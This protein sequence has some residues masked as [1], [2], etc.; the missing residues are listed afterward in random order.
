MQM[1]EKVKK[2]KWSLFLLLLIFV[3]TGTIFALGKAKYSIANRTLEGKYNRKFDVLRVYSKAPG[4]VWVACRMVDI[5]DHVIEI[6]M[7]DNCRGIIREYEDDVYAVIVSQEVEELLEEDLKQFFAKCWVWVD[8]SDLRISDE[9]FDPNTASVEDIIKKAEIGATVG[10]CYVD[11][12]IDR[13]EGTG[14][15]YEKE[16]LYF[17]QGIENYIEENKIFQICLRL[18]WV[19]EEES[20]RVKECLMSMKTKGDYYDM[21]EPLSKESIN[22]IKKAPAYV[23]SK[24]EYIL[25]REMF[26]NE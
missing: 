3:A 18:I 12:F 7:T 22:F 21:I 2:L 1:K 23:G 9:L 10:G 25:R 4:Q 16:Y 6:A 13:Q 11:I 26:E 15:M 19:T 20:E 5:P 8:T 17:T 24:E 14:K